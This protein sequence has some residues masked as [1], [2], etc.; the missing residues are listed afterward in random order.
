MNRKE[1]GARQRGA[2]RGNA[3]CV[4]VSGGLDSAVLAHAM[5]RR[6]ARVFPLYVRTGLRWEA[7]E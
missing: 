3:V 5:A 2:S 6:Y 4:L 7:V 1:A